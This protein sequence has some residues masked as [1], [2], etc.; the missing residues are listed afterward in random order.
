MTRVQELQVE[1]QRTSAAIAHAERTL[2]ANPTIPSVAATLRTIQR[3]QQNL[4]EQFFAATSMQG[5]DVCGYRHI[6]CFQP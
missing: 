3:R 6:N 4:E 1:L 2:A 5:L